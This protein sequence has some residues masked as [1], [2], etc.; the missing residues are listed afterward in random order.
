MVTIGLSAASV[1][2]EAAVEPASR[3]V[4]PV[5]SRPLARTGRPFAEVPVPAPCIK[6]VAKVDTPRG[7]PDVA[8]LPVRR[9]ERVALGE[10]VGAVVTRPTASL[11][12]PEEPRSA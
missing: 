9:E 10:D 1:L 6:A 8:A 12:L 5:F 7:T 2:V 11:T 3:S 4:S